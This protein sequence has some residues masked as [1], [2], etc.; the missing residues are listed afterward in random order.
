M[1]MTV[2]LIS[3]SMAASRRNKGGID[4]N[5]GGSSS[6]SISSVG[7]KD[8]G[9]SGILGSRQS[10]TDRSEGYW[11]VVL[12][13]GNSSRGLN[14]TSKCGFPTNASRPGPLMTVSFQA[15]STAGS[16]YHILADSETV[17]DLN[18]RIQ[19]SCSSYL[20]VGISIHQCNI[21]LRRRCTLR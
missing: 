14:L 9:D 13:N 3:N 17:N 6:V 10:L 8:Y 19:L 2:P 11:P 12:N 16:I 4:S 18:G 1:L 15:N 5:K 7:T 21:I 20:A